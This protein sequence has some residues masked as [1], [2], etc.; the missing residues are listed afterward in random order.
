MGLKGP[1]HDCEATVW[2]VL[3]GRGEGRG[4]G[5][6][7]LSHSLMIVVHR[8]VCVCVCVQHYNVALCFVVTLL[9]KQCCSHGG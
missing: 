9:K 7:S 5:R 6:L 2:D 1:S 4:G 3:L 8:Y